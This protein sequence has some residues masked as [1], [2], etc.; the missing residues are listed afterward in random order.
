VLVSDPD[1]GLPLARVATEAVARHVRPDALRY[2]PDEPDGAATVE[3]V[4]G[5]VLGSTG[6]PPASLLHLATHAD[7]AVTSTGS[8]LL[9]EDDDLPLAAVLDAAAVRT[10]DAP[11]G[12]I[13]CDACVTDTVRHDHDE[14][15]TLAT[16]FLTAGAR[17][18]IGT[19][20]P[21]DDDAAA[22]MAYLLH[23][24][25]LRQPN[26][27]QALRAAQLAMLEGDFPEEMP[28]LLRRP[29]YPG[30]QAEPASWAAYTCHGA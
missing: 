18:V 25:L 17:G 8:S 16:T 11:G 23:A 6:Q 19:R 24:E 21:V 20:W 13:V 26:A 29:T 1:G 10:V 5:E 14:S 3:L 27:A 15:L 22:T 2:G 9:L 28:E 12:L 7:A 4:L 30:R